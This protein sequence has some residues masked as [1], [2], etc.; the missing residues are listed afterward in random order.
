MH[1]QN[2]YQ[3]YCRFTFSVGPQMTCSRCLK[4]GEDGV[5]GDFG[6]SSTAVTDAEINED[7]ESDSGSVSR[8]SRRRRPSSEKTHNRIRETSNPME[9][10]VVP[11]DDD[12]AELMF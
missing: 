2:D 11:K 7:T 3:A 5:D 6:S 1:I 8:K 12:Q 4:D 9:P 10:L